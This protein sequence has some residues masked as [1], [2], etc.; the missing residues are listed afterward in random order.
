MK[1]MLTLIFI[2]LFILDANSNLLRNLQTNSNPFDYSEYTATSVNENLFNEELSCS[3]K[4]QSVV[5]IVV[6]DLIIDNS[7]ISKTLGDSSNIKDSQ[8]YGVNSAVL[9]QGGG[10]LI[11]DGA[12]STASIG[13][14]AI[15]AT[16]NGKINISGTTIVSTGKSTASG[17]YATYGGNIIAKDITA[18]TSGE[19]SATLGTDIG[20]GTITCT[21][22]SL[23][24]S[25][26][27]SPLIYSKGNM[28]IS[29][30]TGTSDGA[31]A[32]IVNG[33]STTTITNLS[34]LKCKGIGN[35]N[36][37]DKCAI[38]IYQSLTKD[39][40]NGISTFNCENSKIEII[41]ESSVYSSAPI[42]FITNT[43]A[44]IN[45][46]ECTF[47]YGSKVFLTI[48]GT[49]EWGKMGDNGGNVVLNLNNQYIDGNFIVDD[50]S[51]LTLKMENST[52][53]GAIN[54]NKN[55]NKLEIIL[56]SYSS[57]I[58]TG[59]SYYTFIKNEDTTGKNIINGSY[60][61]SYYDKTKKD[62]DDDDNDDST[63]SPVKT[64]SGNNY[65]IF[66]CIIFILLI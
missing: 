53:K 27:G 6:S 42:F 48:S 13:A 23:L 16:N 32:V 9:V 15:C 17:L 18:S 11:N 10:V 30:T 57:I 31:Q 24:S 54:N 43:Y 25:G 44:N 60:S 64:S 61:L 63:I 14:H 37:V 12:I 41:S 21:D 58:L 20:D 28:I 66:I 34:H 35:T 50:Y 33:K 2:F 47:I 56:D 38:M 22:C 46:N 5:Y 59:N 29:K 65:S 55:A 40:E 45:L 49:S 4:D 36:N 19:S 51:E 8:L 39:S 52:I 62:D 1:K 7:G 26:E 3:T